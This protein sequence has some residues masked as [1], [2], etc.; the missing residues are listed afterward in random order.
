MPARNRFLLDSLQRKA[1]SAS[2]GLCVFISHRQ[3]DTAPA[4][5]LADFLLNGL[6]IDVYFDAYDQALA[7]ASAAID[8]TKIVDFIETGLEASTHLLGIFSSRTRGSWWVP[9]EVGS[10]S[11]RGRSL[12]HVILDELPDLP[13]YLCRSQLIIDHL[14]L[15]IWAKSLKPELRSKSLSAVT[16]SVSIPRLA[17]ARST[18]PRLIRDES[19]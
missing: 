5:A 19:R 8:D 10:A 9:F 15:A 7:A 12:A 2:D 11:G 6:E 18:P 4:Q 17:R 14:E 16:D 13:S 1:A 3:S